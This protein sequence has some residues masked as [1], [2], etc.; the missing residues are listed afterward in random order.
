MASVSTN[1]TSIVFVH[2]FKLPAK[3]SKNCSSWK[4]VHLM[5]GSVATSED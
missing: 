5:E 4:Y 1:V 3:K 2:L